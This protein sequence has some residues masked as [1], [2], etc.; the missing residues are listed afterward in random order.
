MNHDTIHKVHA[1]INGRRDAEPM[2]P[3]T[4]GTSW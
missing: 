4:Y 2:S 3:P 1:L